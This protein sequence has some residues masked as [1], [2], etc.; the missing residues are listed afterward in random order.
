MQKQVLLDMLIQ[1]QTT[2][3]FAFN[4]ITEENAGLRLNE[5]TASAGFIYRHIGGMMNMFG[6]FFGL[7]TDVQNTTMGQSDTGQGQDI[8]TSRTLIEEG[9]KTFQNHV[10]N[11]PDSAWLN[12]VE[13]PFFGTVSQA[14]LFGHV[15]FHN[16]HHAGQIAM[17]LNRGSKIG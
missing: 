16:A 1:N 14:R 10:K 13:T 7:P 15:L 12:P 3:S 9:Y 17:T 11:T 5:Q 2:C 4:Q 6:L 8:E